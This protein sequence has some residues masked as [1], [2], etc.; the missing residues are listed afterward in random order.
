MNC[1]C[2]PG[3]LAVKRVSNKNNQNRGKEFYVCPTQSCNFFLWAD[4]KVP[5]TL[6]ARVPPSSSSSFRPNSS[7]SSSISNNYGR[8]N[9]QQS[10]PPSNL[11]TAKMTLVAIENNT[12]YV[13]LTCQYNVSINN[14]MQKHHDCCKFDYSRK[15][16]TFDL[17]IYD[18]V[19]QLLRDAGYQPEELPRFLSDG[20]RKYF[21]KV[22]RPS[23]ASS[24]SS[25]SSHQVY[26]M[27]NQEKERNGELLNQP[28]DIKLNIS[29]SL[30][31]ILLPFQV[32]GVKF[33]IN[34]CGRGLIGDEMGCGK[35]IQ[36]IALLQHYRAHWPAIVLIPTNLMVQW[37]EELLK[38]CHDCLSSQDICCVKT[39]KDH[40]YGKITI[41]PYSLIGQFVDR[42]ELLS[43][44]FGMIIA[45]ESHKLKNSDSKTASYVVPL[46]K[47][48][49]IA[50]C[51]SGTPMMNRPV[52]L[53]TQ[54]NG[55][56]PTIF[57][58]YH[59]FLFRYCDAKQDSLGFLDKKGASN[60]N[61][62]KL[63]LETFIMIRRLKEQVIQELPDKKRERLY[64][65]VDQSYA[66]EINRI[67]KLTNYIDSEMKN[68]MKDQ[69]EKRK[70]S[71][72]REQLLLEYYRVTG[73][74]K[75]GGIKRE[76][77]RLIEAARVQKAIAESALDEAEKEDKDK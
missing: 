49:P 73:L 71:Q 59:G 23:P 29:S 11:P 31:S 62:L 24:S 57:Y 37:K 3:Q 36:A 4:S 12:A 50:I 6:H 60:E 28:S 27:Q 61:E 45:D 68:P 21:A 47:T 40:L 67:Q 35:T 15:L 66:G 38:Y 42:Q 52:E 39:G 70:L 46:L 77:L 30:S 13:G 14:F 55:L 75:I 32:E 74:S 53:Y 64:V 9:A 48:I 5:V 63:L 34:H 69:E 18:S 16:W 56:Q 17:K 20:I 22:Q 76:V 41:I 44:R 58:D 10:A 43:E 8:T 72:Q 54:L 51:L 33:I 26:G 19:V 25:S 7:S 2:Q 1:H 65:E